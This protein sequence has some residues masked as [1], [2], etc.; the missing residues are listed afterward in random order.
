[1]GRRTGAG[2]AGALAAGCAAK[3]PAQPIPSSSPPTL[4]PGTPAGPIVSP[5]TFA[6][7]SSTQT[8]PATPPAVAA[9][10]NQVTGGPGGSAAQGSAIVRNLQ[11]VADKDANTLLVMRGVG[12]IG[13]PGAA[14]VVNMR[15]PDYLLRQGVRQLP[16]VKAS[17]PRRVSASTPS[18]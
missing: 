11:V 4:A 6:P 8:P 7:Q 3:R 13:Y 17:S 15:P 9:V 12:P 16:C 1:M 14:E 2:I 5:P 10:V 18:G